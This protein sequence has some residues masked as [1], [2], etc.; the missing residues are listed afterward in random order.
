LK[1]SHLKLILALEQFGRIT[2]AADALATTQ[3]AASRMLA[4]MERILGAEL[5]EREP[6]GMKLTAIGQAVAR[7]ARNLL[8][9]MHS[10][11][12]DI[13]EMKSGQGGTVRVGAVTSAAVSYVVPAIQQ[14]KA[15][16]PSINVYLDVAPSDK[17]VR[18][19]QAGYHDFILGRIPVGIDP[20]LFNVSL[21]QVEEVALV[22]RKDHP[23]SKSSNI[24]L[25]DLATY[26]WVAQNRGSPIRDAVD[27]A[28]MMSGAQLPSRVTNTSSLLVTLAILSNSTAIS[29][30][31]RV[32]SDLLIGRDIGM[33]LM[34][35]RLQETIVIEPY[36][37]MTVAGRH[38]SP[39]ASRLQHLV[40]SEIQRQPLK[41]MARAR[42]DLGRS[43]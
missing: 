2:V 39:T 33:R 22:V 25:E 5:C 37:V 35:L 3:P 8:S 23:L 10:L 43:A 12:R 16:Y 30:L 7:R 40:L 21:G 41:S 11:S 36:N 13:E 27:T 38:P 26:D 42:K 17:L 28:F 15:A 14:L 29:P 4:D 32:V 31:S 1:N 34:R 18:D 20:N 6:R 24:S 9:E 19:L